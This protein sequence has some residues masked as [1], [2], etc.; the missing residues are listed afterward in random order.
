MIKVCVFG[1]A[2][3]LGSHVADALSDKGYAVRIFDRQDSRWRRDDQDVVIGDLLDKKA[4]TAAVAGCQVV[5]N[6]AALAD[7]DAGL[8]DP[9][10]TIRINILGNAHVMEACRHHDV[11]RF[12]YASSVYVFSRQGGFYRCSKQASEHYVEEYQRAYGL[13]YTILRYGSLYGPRSG[14][15]NGLYRMVKDALET[16]KLC[17]TGSPESTR[18]YIH[19]ED[20]ARASVTALGDDAFINQSVV[21]TGHEPMRVL[22]M[23]KMLAEILGIVD[24]VEFVAG[25]QTGHYVRTPYAYQP[26]LGRKYIPPLHVD[27]GQGLIQLMEYIRHEK[28]MA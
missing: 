25:E 17:Y 20:A 10:E 26:K 28:G 24:G 1:G 27:L 22:D 16:G 23:L 5:Y 11:Q 15:N 2:G 13:N 7:L 6:F 8:N 21:L 3:F 14:T 18:E 19:V 12:F 9:L 4:V